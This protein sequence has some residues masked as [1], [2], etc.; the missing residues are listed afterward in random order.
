MAEFVIAIIPFL[1]ILFA[2]MQLALCSLA[3]LLVNQAAFTAARAAQVVLPTTTQL[4][5]NR[6]E[7]PGT[8]GDGRD[9]AADYAISKKLARIRNAAI[10]A[11]IPASPLIDSL[12]SS[13]LSNGGIYPA[14]TREAEATLTGSL[15][16][17]RSSVLGALDPQNPVARSVSKALDGDDGVTDQLER[18]VRKLI[19][20]RMLTGVTLR[21]ARGDL[22][23]SFGP[24]EDIT[25]RVTYLFPCQIPLAGRFAGRR[26]DALD[27]GALADL[28]AAGVSVAQLGTLPGYFM[29]LTAEHTVVNQ[30]TP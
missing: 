6:F 2:V 21:D 11:L 12:A 3:R 4:A 28:D 24:N 17:F 1:L 10:Y 18:S 15:A 16:P 8:L 26:V 29:V 13:S 22:R 19:S 30:G 5:P 25:A 7:Q 27:P 20:A 9:S 14:A 23:S